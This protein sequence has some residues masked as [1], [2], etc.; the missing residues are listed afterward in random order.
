MLGEMAEVVLM[1]SNV[2]SEKTKAT[3]FEYKF[4]DAKKAVEN[5]MK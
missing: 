5:L 2:S 1:G 3:G 4:T